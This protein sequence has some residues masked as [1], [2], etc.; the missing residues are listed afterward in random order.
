M[1]KEEIPPKI[2]TQEN[3]I[4]EIERDL[5]QQLGDGIE[6]IPESVMAM[7]YEKMEITSA[8]T[9]SKFGEKAMRELF[10]SYEQKVL[11]NGRMPPMGE[12]E[13]YNHF[14]ERIIGLYRIF[15]YGQELSPL[16]QF[17]ESQYLSLKLNKYNGYLKSGEKSI[18]K[19]N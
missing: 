5:S 2:F 15:Y 12:V 16:E 11:L 14:L 6:T 9:F 4:S 13:K 17:I 8:Y 18:R 10:E 7:H 3:P 19:K 1:R